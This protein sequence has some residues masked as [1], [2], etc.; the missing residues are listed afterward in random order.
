MKQKLITLSVILVLAFG[1]SGTGFNS[2]SAQDAAV[3]GRALGTTR[4]TCPVAIRTQLTSL[5]AEYFVLLEQTLE[6]P[7]LTSE[8]LNDLYQDFL[9]L[10]QRLENVLR[11]PVLQTGSAP[12]NVQ[13]R[14]DCR[15]VFYFTIEQTQDVFAEYV[16]QVTARKR[17]FILNEKY[18]QIAEGL[19]EMQ[20][21][22][23]SIESNFG[24]F[25][26]QLPCIVEQC[27]QR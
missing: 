8:Q 19:T 12:E 7:E 9:D 20:D 5:Q 25:E 14:Q 4:N 16:S 27:I 1:L 11:T 21:V 2:S 6:S 10:K 26:T 13:V 3:E 17:T 24:T 23:H 18:D 15:E 22:L